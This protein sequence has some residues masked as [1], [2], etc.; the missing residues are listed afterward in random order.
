MF[1]PAAINFLGREPMQW[2]IGQVTDPEKGEWADSQERKNGEDG[3][4]VYSHRCRVRIVGYHGND[5]DLPDKDLPMAH[6][7]LPPGVSTTGGRGETMNYQ[8]GEV[9]VGFFFD[10]VDG[11]QPVIFGTLFKQTFVRDGLTDDQFNAFNQT[12]FIPYTPPKVKQAAGKDKVAPQSPWPFNFKNQ[13]VLVANKKSGPKPK[14]SDF[15]RN[16]NGRGL[17]LRALREWKKLATVKPNST[18][19]TK[20]NNSHTNVKFEN[21]TGCED[22][23][24]SKISN[25]LKD[26]TKEMNVLEN[27]GKLTVDPRYGGVVSRESE[28]KLASMEIHK[29]MSKLMRRGRS[30]VIQDTLDKVSK[31]MRDKTPSTLQPAVSSATKGLTDKIFCNFEKINEQLMDYLTKSLENMLGSVLDVP[32]C[33]VES[34]LGDMFGQINNILDTNLGDTF[35]QLNGITGGGGAGGGGI[36]PPSKTF[37]KAIKFANILTNTLDCDVLN[38]P[39]NT[40]FTS[41]GGTAISG[42]DDFKNILDI[43]GLNSLKNKA[44][45]LKDM[46]DGLVPDISVPSIPKIDCNTNVLKCG[47]PRIDF[48]GGGGEGA[49][50]S[51]IVNALGNVIGVAIDNGG[52]NF[53]EPPLLSFVDGCDNGYGAGGY[54]RIQ[55][56]SVVDVVITAG[57][58]EYIPNTTE[59]DMDGN[60]KEIIPDPNANYDGSTSY[61]TKL[62]DV[63]I[64][65]VGFGYEEGDTVTVDNGAEVELEIVDGRIVGANIV[66]AGFGFTELPK[67]TI[68]SNTG[69][70]AR[71]FPVLEFTKIDD[72][73]QVANIS[74][75]VVVTVIDCI[76]K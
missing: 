23:E 4:D 16:R 72:A 17:Y 56:G 48:I 2:W 54:A 65:N 55:D 63:V 9:V 27:V 57:G 45:G 43:A 37:S 58:H 51:A 6:V 38:C 30:W 13:T 12:E 31:T 20:Q 73:A 15:P 70:L 36:Q 49:S 75:D 53:T 24:I 25:V 59:T 47:P 5:A 40:A 62:S 21:A 33:A 76:T 44:Q 11:Q 3:D 35:S 29:S 8:G 66:N 34:F 68:N 7:L 52:N 61:V 28:I 50:G 67:L 32:L 22:N 41:K 19:G 39:P 64:E 42:V 60:V 1:D 10:G 74:Q 14:V 18:V 26:F 71:I 69:S 46:V